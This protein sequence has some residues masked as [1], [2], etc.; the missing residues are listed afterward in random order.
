MWLKN[1]ESYEMRDYR[2]KKKRGVQKIRGK[3]ESNYFNRMVNSSPVH[4]QT[5]ANIH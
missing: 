4:L 3:K 2:E 5:N 1:C